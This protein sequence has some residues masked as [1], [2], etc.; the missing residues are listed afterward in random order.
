MPFHPF[1]PLAPAAALAPWRPSPGR[2][3]V[4]RPNCLMSRS[5]HSD[6]SQTTAGQAF[7]ARLRHAPATRTPTYVVR[8]QPRRRIVGAPG[9]VGPNDIYRPRGAPGR[10]IIRNVVRIH[11]SAGAVFKAADLMGRGWTGVH[12]CDQNQ[13]IFWPD[14]FDQLYVVRKIGRLAARWSPNRHVSRMRGSAQRCTPDPEPSRRRC[15]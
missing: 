13:R 11:P 15:V 9:K 8:N 7:G 2:N 10:A 3:N 4:E 6:P 12:I 5:L 14:A 1:V